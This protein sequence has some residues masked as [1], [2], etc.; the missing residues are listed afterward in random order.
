MRNPGR[1]PSEFGDLADD[2]VT[3]IRMPLPKLQW[4]ETS[5]RVTD[6]R[7]LYHYGW[8]DE[9]PEG[10]V[11]AQGLDDGHLAVEVSTVGA[12]STH[13]CRA[14]NRWSWAGERG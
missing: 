7:F 1:F 4:F 5:A 10:P 2:L 6:D 14:G 8:P 11:R 3:V 9:G 13:T 12:G